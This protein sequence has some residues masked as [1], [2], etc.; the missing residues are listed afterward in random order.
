M[1]DGVLVPD[2]LVVDLVM[3]NLDGKGKVLLD[4][5]PRSLEQAKQLDQQYPI[6]MVVNLEVPDAEILRRL[7]NRRV[8]VPSGRVYHLLWNPPKVDGRDDE[9]GE[10]LV[11]RPDDTHASILRRLEQYHELNAP[12]IAYY[13]ERGVLQS[14]AGTESNV[15]YPEMESYIDAWF[16]V[17]MGVPER[18]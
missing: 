15:I 11:H 18:A 16:S 12:L 7:E 4:G 14:F 13:K 5:F 1:K 6:D 3:Q 10:E 8:H 9:T 17:K 2:S